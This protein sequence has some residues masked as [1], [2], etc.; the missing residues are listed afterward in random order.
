[1]YGQTPLHDA[2]GQ[3]HSNCA[4]ILIRYGADINKTWGPSCPPIFDAI[5][6]YSYDC[7]K[8]LLQAGADLSF[9]VAAEGGLDILHWLARFADQNTWVLFEHADF[10]GIDGEQKTYDGETPLQLL[11]REH[12]DAT[13]DLIASFE[14]LLA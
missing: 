7:I 13:E 2:V 3:N 5:H 12:Q 9:V 8:L 6:T 14:S 1:L 10:T 11:I 4:E